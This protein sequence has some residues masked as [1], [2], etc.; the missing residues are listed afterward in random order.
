MCILIAQ[1]AGHIIPDE[2]LANGWRTNQDGGGFAYVVNHRVV[3]EKPFFDFQRFHDRYKEIVAQHPDSVVMVHMRIT[4]HGK[5]DKTNT[6]PHRIHRGLAVG[7]NGIISIRTCSE[8]SDTVQYC[9]QIISKL[10]LT[11]LDNEAIK[12]LIARDIG[13]GNKLCF[14]RG[15]NTLHI[16]NAEAGVYDEGIWYSNTSYRTYKWADTGYGYIK[17]DAYYAERRKN[18]NRYRQWEYED[19][20]EAASIPTKAEKEAAEERK[21]LDAW[22]TRQDEDTKARVKEAMDFPPDDKVCQRYVEEDE[23]ETDDDDAPIPADREG[24]SFLVEFF[25]EDEVCVTDQETG[26][27]GWMTPGPDSKYL[28]RVL[29]ETT[30]GGD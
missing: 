21:R 4:T 7:H 29:Y 18:Y 11:F 14:V 1:P 19:E 26:A 24:T 2:H 28:H 12:L 30:L 16:I 20:I 17:N 13:T 25:E 9:R 15:D 27:E 23:G 10:P 5:N 6:H 3:I 8:F 22:L